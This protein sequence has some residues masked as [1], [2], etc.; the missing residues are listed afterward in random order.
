MTTHGKRRAPAAPASKRRKTGDAAAAAAATRFFAE[1]DIT[2]TGS[3][4]P[5]EACVRLEDAPFAPALI[6]ALHAQG[7]T[8]PSAVQ[9]VTWP[10]A[11]RDVDVLAIA[12]TGQGKTLAYLLPALSRSASSDAGARHKSAG[13]SCLVVVP[14]RELALQVQA[15]AHKFGAALGLRASAWSKWP[16]LHLRGLVAECRPP[17]PKRPRTPREARPLTHSGRPPGRQAESP[18]RLDA[19]EKQQRQW[20]SGTRL[21]SPRCHRPLVTALW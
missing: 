5:P 14:T 12:G 16:D 18:R 4:A 13:P 11:M 10:L 8:A 21:E 6:A 7:F 19:P 3:A 17:L 2:V 15:E 1:H 9:G 20:H